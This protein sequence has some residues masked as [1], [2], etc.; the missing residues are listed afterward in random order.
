MNIMK[1]NIFL[2]G[3][4]GV[5]KTTIGEL[6]ANKLKLKFFDVDKEI[7]NLQNKSITDIFLTE[8]EK[9]FRIYESEVISKLC[10]KKNV[11]LAAGGGAVLRENNREKLKKNGIIVYLYAEINDLIFRLKNS[12]E[13]PLLNYRSINLEYSLKN[14]LKEREI[15]YEDLKDIKINT[16]D[17]NFD[18]ILNLICKSLL[19]FNS[20]IG[21]SPV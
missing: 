19:N 11:V 17:L 16:S 15:F 12:Y 5:G 9:Y 3:L 14:I 13:R 21:N 20:L 6:L 2:I 4:P 1:R 10:L 18:Q 7:E 8:G